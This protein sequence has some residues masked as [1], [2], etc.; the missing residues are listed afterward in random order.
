[1]KCHL[2][3]A[4]IYPSV[5]LVENHLLSCFIYLFIQVG[6]FHRA[7]PLVPP[8]VC[9]VGLLT[10]LVLHNY[11]INLWVTPISFLI[12][13][14]CQ[15][16]M[17]REALK[18]LFWVCASLC[19]CFGPLAEAGSWDNSAFGPGQQN[20]PSLSKVG[21][22]FLPKLPGFLPKLPRPTNNNVCYFWILA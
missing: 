15:W 20:H 9:W 4:N 1:M 19:G 7:V 6:S 22:G 16:N 14:C 11:E 21:L 5:C 8:S 3:Y 17:P 2:T 18:G 10:A 13:Y 12:F